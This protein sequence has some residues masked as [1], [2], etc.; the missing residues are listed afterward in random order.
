MPREELVALSA[1]VEA[2]E[3]VAEQDRRAVATLTATVA[4]H[5]QL[6]ETQQAQQL[7][8]LAGRVSTLEAGAAELACRE[9]DLAERQAGAERQKEQQQV[10]WGE[11]LKDQETA[12][13]EGLEARAASW[14]RRDEVEQLRGEMGRQGERLESSLEAL[15]RACERQSQR[16]QTS[17]ESACGQRE[18]DEQRQKHMADGLRSQL[19]N[20]LDS[21]QGE[22]KAVRDGSCHTQELVAQTVQHA[23]HPLA[24]KMDESAQFTRRVKM[25]MGMIAARVQ[26]RVC[27][28]SDSVDQIDSAIRLSAKHVEKVG[29]TCADLRVQHGSLL[30]QHT[31]HKRE[32]HALHAETDKQLAAVR[33][34]REA[35]VEKRVG[36][37]AERVEAYA[38]D[39][40]MKARTDLKAS[41]TAN[42]V[43]VDQRLTTGIASKVVDELAALTGRFEDTLAADKCELQAI[44]DEMTQELE[45]LEVTLREDLC[46]MEAELSVKYLGSSMG[47]PAPKSHTGIAGVRLDFERQRG[48]RG[49]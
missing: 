6:L 21:L 32:I 20:Q 14:V 38:S 36:H 40:I 26:E 39:A 4:G 49:Q 35:L 18:L 46:R 41:I 45:H 48:P 42:F 33:D 2:L 16:L 31:A 13:L 7:Q 9:A 24:A 23:M 17:E 28:L 11:K 5:S 29:I 27:A 47:D 34:E 12:I 30:E 25:E 1:Q 19:Q 3:A 15:E 37:I 44:R 22:L 43:A 10:A 8:V